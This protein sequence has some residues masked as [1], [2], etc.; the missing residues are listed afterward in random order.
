MLKRK[1]GRVLYIYLRED[2]KV[3]GREIIAFEIALT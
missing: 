1:L 3:M 2:K